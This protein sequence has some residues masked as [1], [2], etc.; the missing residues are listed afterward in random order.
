MRSE[1]GHMF[2]EEVLAFRADAK[3]L[4]GKKKKTL[5]SHDK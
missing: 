5:F 4:K 1:R 2:L 3:Q